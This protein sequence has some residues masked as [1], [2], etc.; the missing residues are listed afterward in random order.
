MC[1]GGV[2]SLGSIWVLWGKK[3]FIIFFMVVIERFIFEF[4]YFFCGRDKYEV[5]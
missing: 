1:V 4:G 2:F 3:R 5:S